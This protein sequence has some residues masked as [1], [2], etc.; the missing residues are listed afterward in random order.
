MNT[1]YYLQFAD[2]YFRVVSEQ[3]G[4]FEEQDR[5]RQAP[6]NGFDGGFDDDDDFDGND[7]DV[8]DVQPQRDRD[9]SRDGARDGNRDT[10]REQGRE[11]NREPRRFDGDRE[12]GR[13]AP[14]EQNREER[15][16]REPRRER[17]RRDEPREAG[18]TEGLPAVE[19]DPIESGEQQAPR[20]RRARRVE[21]PAAP[22]AQADTFDASRLPPSF[23]PANDGGEAPADDEAEAKPR[24]R[25]LRPAGEA[26][27]AG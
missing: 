19:G 5:Q 10:G 25:R 22:V 15:A 12:Q 23:A 18:P 17:F 24:R 9:D 1:E 27:Q 8:R 4:R 14:R 20:P 13:E 16:P 21:A 6:Q 2:H 3:R 11:Q 7:G 26:T